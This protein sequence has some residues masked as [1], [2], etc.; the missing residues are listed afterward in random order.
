MTPPPTAAERLRE[1]MDEKSHATLPEDELIATRSDVRAVL[2]DN[3]RLERD[4]AA[5]REG[6]SP[7][8]EIADGYHE[9]A[10]DQWSIDDAISEGRIAHLTIGDLR[11]ARAILSGS[12]PAARWEPKLV[13]RDD[14]YL[15]LGDF[16]LGLIGYNDEPNI[17]ERFYAWLISTAG[18][19]ATYHGI[20]KV[21]D[22]ARLA[23]ESAARKAIGWE[24]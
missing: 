23:V 7:F 9:N 22:E 13:W 15:Y 10:K 18:T 17:G 16:K 5:A 21:K 8:A 24:G 20:F 2:V 14:D 12:A 19:T 1:L 4:L 6:L 11:R 3:D